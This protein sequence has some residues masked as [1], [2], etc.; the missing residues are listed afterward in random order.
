MN[1]LRGKYSSN[2]MAC[3]NIQNPIRSTILI[4]LI[5]SIPFLITLLRIL[6]LDF[7]YDEIFTLSR[8]VF[9]SIKNTLTYYPK[10]N[11]HIFHNMLNNIY[12]KMLGIRD[13]S[14]LMNSPYKIRL[15][16]FL[17]TS[18][19]IGFVYSIGIK[20]FNRQ[21]AIFSLVIF[22]TSIPLYN[23]A[24]QIRGYVLSVMFVSMLI[25]LIFEYE[26]NPTWSKLSGIGIIVALLLYSI[27][28]NIYPVLAFG[29]IYLIK[30]WQKR[31]KK[32]LYL[33]IAIVSGGIT[34]IFFYIPIWET[35][36]NNRFTRSQ[37]L[38]HLRI[39]LEIFPKVIYYFISARYLII[40]IIL[41]GIIL[42]YKEIK[43]QKE[44]FGSLMENSKILGVVF[45]LPFIFSYIRG[46]R[47]WDRIFINLLPVFSI[48]LG[49]LLYFALLHKKLKNKMVYITL[50]IIIYS[51]VTFAV[52]LGKIN[53][54]KDILEG[55]KTQNLYYYY[56]L[57]DY[58]PRKLLQHFLKSEKQNKPVILYECDKNAMPAYLNKFKVG[59]H[60]FY[61][62]EE[63]KRPYALKDF[64]EKE[65]EVYVITIFPVKFE[66]MLR[67]YFTEFEY[68]RLN[69][70][71]QFDNIYLVKR[72]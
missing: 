48:G 63:E 64:L 58:Q 36:V 2:E 16:H 51:Y 32:I 71:L 40:V 61:K 42:N 18:V 9:T 49:T 68:I 72:K 26:N 47:A 11:N 14:T 62:Y 13:L 7:W 46:D 50:G 69:E 25:Y 27:P 57:S 29:I 3:E 19:A 66:K 54:K 22:V 33:V 28:L 1:I 53:S 8:F 4:G 23:F 30:L 44:K 31:T 12:L 17:Y 70:K 43:F 6:N 39:L 45:M 38:F 55:K 21:I 67:L 10:P 34:A 59:Y 60:P 52:Q 41:I 20:F 37:G 15:L 24:L 65:N 5:I 35:V 56:Y